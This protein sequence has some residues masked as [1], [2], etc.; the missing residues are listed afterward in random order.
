VG[1]VFP[2][3]ACAQSVTRANQIR[4]IPNGMNRGHVGGHK[5]PHFRVDE[6]VF[7]GISSDSKKSM[8]VEAEIRDFFF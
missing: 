7:V 6:N 8:G 4:H 5:L 3:G 2:L 1:I